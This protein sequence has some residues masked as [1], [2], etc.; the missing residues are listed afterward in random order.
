MSPREPINLDEYKDAIKTFADSWPQKSVATLGRKETIKSATQ[1]M[2]LEVKLLIQKGYTVDEVVVGLKGKGILISSA[3]LKS[4]FAVAKAELKL[5]IGKTKVSRKTKM[6][7]ST[8]KPSA[9]DAPP[10][11]STETSGTGTKQDTQTKLTKGAQISSDK[12]I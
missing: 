10:G 11:E 2:M 3:T 4:Y 9:K 6:D 5:M 8:T 12:D 7:T 1:S